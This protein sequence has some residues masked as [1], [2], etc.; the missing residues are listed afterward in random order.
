[1]AGLHVN[2]REALLP[3]FE[4]VVRASSTVI[5]VVCGVALP[6]FAVLV[7]TFYGQDFSAAAP[8]L[9]VLG[10]AGA[11]LAAGGPVLAFTMGRL[12]SGRM[13]AANATA[14]AIDVGLAMALIPVLGVWG[15]V[16]ANLAGALSRLVLLIRAEID[17]LGLGWL[18]LANQ[19]LPALLAMPIAAACW[20]VGDGLASLPAIP[21]ALVVGIIGLTALVV[22][23]RT[24]RCGLTERDRQV[25]LNTVPRGLAPA[26]AL[27]L[28]FLT[29]R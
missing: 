7:P 5:S 20:L 3:A 24:T 4:R 12:S 11:A 19:A 25:V 22:G 18:R 2:D 10:I 9:V 17:A 27:L 8:L 23:L 1:M 26:T 13:L 29:H 14:L 21:T 16:I 15:A 28:R 6:A